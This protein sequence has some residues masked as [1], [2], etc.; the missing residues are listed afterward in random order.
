MSCARSSHSF[1]RLRSKIVL[2]CAQGLDNKQVAVKLGVVPATV[3]KWRRRFVDR[4][5]DGLLDEPRPGGPRSIGDEQIEAWFGGPERA[6]LDRTPT[7]L[8]SLMR[9]VM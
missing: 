6:T 4:R 3:G 2:A 8:R 5:L 1:W 7:P 9:R